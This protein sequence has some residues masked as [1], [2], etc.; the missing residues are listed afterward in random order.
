MC[1]NATEWCI[2]GTIKITGTNF[3]PP[4]YDPHFY[5]WCNPPRKHFDLSMPMFV[6]IAQSKAGII[7]VQFRR[8]PCVK[9]GG[10]RFQIT[11]NPNFVM[12]TIMNV[13][14]AGDV[15]AISVKTP[16][17]NWLPMSRNWGQVWN[18]GG[19]IPLVGQIL[20][21]QVTTS[22]KKTLVFNN[23]APGNWQFGQT[24]EAAGNF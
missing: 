12:I 15:I 21:F 23:V 2:P 16:T 17:S 3:C 20:S 7:G 6:K 9:T 14:G 13:A 8:I 18:I 10:V 11:G 24:Y 22:D 19:R 1:H 4:N 5:P